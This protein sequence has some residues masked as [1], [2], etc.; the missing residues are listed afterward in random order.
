MSYDKLKFLFDQLIY[1]AGNHSPY[2][3]AYKG[4]HEDHRATALHA[5][6]RLSDE[7]VQAGL[8]FYGCPYPKVGKGRPKLGFL[9]L[10]ERPTEEPEWVD[11]KRKEFGKSSKRLDRP[12]NELERCIPRLTKL[13]RKSAIKLELPDYESYKKTVYESDIEGI[14]YS[15]IYP[16]SDMFYRVFNENDQSSGRIYGH[17]LQSVKSELRRFITIG[18]ELTCEIDYSAMQLCLAYSLLGLKAPPGDPYMIDA[19]GGSR[20]VFKRIFTVG[21]GSKATGNP[22]RTLS[23]KGKQGK[24][25]RVP[26]D[27]AKALDTAFWKHHHQIDEFRCSEAWKRLQFVESEIA[28]RVITSLLDQK[29]AVLPIHDGFR[30]AKR[31]EAALMTA[32]IEAVS[33]LST[34]PVP[35]LKP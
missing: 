5:Q 10:N 33:K 35:S 31:H 29:I 34:P 11:N 30:V 4:S 2:C 18:G 24:H 28:L 27:Q 9:R 15:N 23:Q 6:K 3:R 13:L 21:I 22:A 20:A 8:I 7:L 25:K 32:M 17:H 1:E 12:A 14:W 26:Y 19:P 16:Y